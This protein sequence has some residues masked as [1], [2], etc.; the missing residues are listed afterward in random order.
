MWRSARWDAAR[1]YEMKKFPAALLV[2]LRDGASVFIEPLY[3]AIAVLAAV[4]LF[5][6]YL[7]VPI[8][9]VPS[10][11]LALELSLVTP[12]GY[13]LL[14]A[15]ALMTGALFALEVFAFQRSRAQKVAAAR[16]SVGLIASLTGGILAA[17]SCGCGVGILLG[18]VGLGGG[19]LFVAANQTAIVALMLVVVAVGLYFSARRAAGLCATCRVS[20]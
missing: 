12:L 4:A 9:L 11:S 13:G 20:S 3:G 14:V 17:A 16:D 7:F 8:W 2:T 18:A 19:T 6:V 1:P 10:N 15:L 5:A